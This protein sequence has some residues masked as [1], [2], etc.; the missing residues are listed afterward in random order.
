MPNSI[1]YTPV[2]LSVRFECR[3]S[4][5][6]SVRYGFCLSIHTYYLKL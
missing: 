4:L 1:S 5:F 3:L 6:R 2:G